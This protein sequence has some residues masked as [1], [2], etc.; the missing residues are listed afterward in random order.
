MNANHVQSIKRDKFIYKLTIFIKG[1]EPL[2]ACC[3]HFFPFVLRLIALTEELLF[4]RCNV[5]SLE[6]I[7]VSTTL[8]RNGCDCR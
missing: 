4:K 2:V 1:C 3:V 8:L 7:V 5:E 6:H